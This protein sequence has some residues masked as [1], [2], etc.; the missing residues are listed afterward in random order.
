MTILICCKI[1][2]D[3]VLMYAFTIAA[4][5]FAIW[6]DVLPDS[7]SHVVLEFSLEARAVV[8]D[9]RP[10]ALPLVVQERAGVPQSRRRPAESSVAIIAGSPLC[11]GSSAKSVDVH[12]T[13]FEF[14]RVDELL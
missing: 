10:S 9:L 4:T 7:V 11:S 5:H 14:D 8:P 13:A 12:R 6:P 2:L 3:Y 1:Y